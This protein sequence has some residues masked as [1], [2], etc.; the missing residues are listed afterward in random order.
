MYNINENLIASSPIV[1]DHLI[2]MTAG[3]KMGDPVCYL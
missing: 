2:A 3:N 1:I